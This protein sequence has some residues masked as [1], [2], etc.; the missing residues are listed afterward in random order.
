MNSKEIESN[1]KQIFEDFSKEEFIYDLLIAYGI[2]KTSITRLKKGDFNLSKV[3]GEILYKKK[4]FFKT[5]ESGNLLSEIENVSVDERITKHSPRFAILTDYNT[6]VAKDLKLKRNLDIKITELPKYFDFFLPLAGSE[7]YNTSNDNQADRDAAYKMAQLYDNLVHA[8]ENIYNSKESIHELNIFLSRLLFCFFAEDTE[9]FEEESIFSKTLSQHTSEDGFDTHEFLDKLFERLNTKDSSSFPAYLQ[10]FPYVNGGLFRDPIDAPHFTFKARKTLLELGDLNWKDINPDIFG[11]MIQAVVLPEYRSDLG[12]HYTS[13]ENILKLIRPLFLDELYEE[14][15]KHNDNQKQLRKLISRL[16]K[17]KFFDPACG[18]GNFLIITYKEIRLLEI[19]I[20]QRIIDLSQNPTLEFT[21]IQLSQFYGIELDDF[22]HEMA[23]LSLWL[24]EHQMNKIF[25]EMLFDYGR[26]KPILPLKDAGQIQQGNSARKSWNEVCP[27]SNNDEVYIIGN[28]PYLG[29]KGWDAEQKKD[30]ATVFNGFK[31]VNRLDYI[32]CWFKKGTDYILGKNAKLAFVSTNSI[33]QGE[34]VSLIWPYV[35]N[36]VNINFAYTSFGW[37]N[38]AK[39]NAGVTVVIISLANKSIAEKIIFTDNRRIKVKNIN[40]YLTGGDNIYISK[41]TNPISKLP[42]MV[43]GSSGI[44]GG[45]L[46]LSKEEKQSFINQNPN[47]EKFIKKFLGGNDF[48]YR[49][50]RYCLWIDDDKIDEASNIEPIKERID[51]C[52]TYRLNAG[53]D[54]RKAAN[55]PHRFFYR[56]YQEK[57]SLILPFTS[58]ERRTY[59]PVDIGKQ[60]TVFSNGMLVIYDFEP[61]HF[62]ILVS[63]L[64]MVWAKA[65][66]GK[67]EERLRYSVSMVYNTF[68]FPE[69]TIKQKENLNLYVFAILDERA[70][71]AE[72]TMA[73]LYDPDIMPKGLKLAHK[74]LD[75]AIEKC[76]RLQPF[77]TDTERLEYLFK[78]YEEMEK[79]NTLFAKQKKKRTVKSDD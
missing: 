6:L 63:R 24:A 51:K 34:Q 43:L 25:E 4:I 10:K 22:A 60:E 68:P 18:S 9:I 33:C 23:I 3:D 45:H 65:V 1:V 41:R 16:S 55:V 54:A 42:Q 14:F 15:E 78:M 59:L 70:K 58:S 7:V 17:I 5:G 44:D 61:Y 66:G 69:I 27:I 37:S 47:S 76:Y 48:L 26:S 50:D 29:F 30:M 19:K 28:P 56:K 12:M 52:L 72:K 77:S 67:L 13:V 31:T 20:L 35:L 2:S 21:Q 57:E 36:H 49:V 40:P 39:G 64:H 75:E 8:N 79:K 74:E 73:Q 46:I 11:S 32:S 38:S 71:Y 62:A 53:R